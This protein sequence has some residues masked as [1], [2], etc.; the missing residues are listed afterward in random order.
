MA[1]SIM[2]GKGSTYPEVPVLIA[3]HS[4]THCLG[5]RRNDD[6]IV[7]INLHGGPPIIYGLSTGWPLPE[8]FNEIVR[9]KSAGMH[10]ML[11]WTGNIHL[12]HFMFAQQKRFDFVSSVL[13]SLPITPDVIVLPESLVETRLAPHAGHLS[14]ALN[15][16]LDGR[17]ASVTLVGTPPPKGDDIVLREV[18]KGD[19][20][21][22]ENAKR[23]GFEPE[24]VPF[25][26]PYLRLKL[27]ALTQK[28]TERVAESFKIGFLP[29][30]PECQDE[31]GFLKP[32]YWAKDITHANAAYGALLI[33]HIL[34]L[35]VVEPIP[36]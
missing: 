16:I 33:E 30:P 27:W 32:E 6:Q 4:H 17:A 9:T 35:S 18:L 21:F 22:V 31:V 36:A 8:N 29:V 3:G 15:S 7:P 10:L 12:A 24:T 5:L 14:A 2:F 11:V 19:P 23:L 1:P 28:M 26:S 25:N 20:V 34:K 13:P